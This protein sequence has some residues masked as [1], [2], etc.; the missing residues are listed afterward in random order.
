MTPPSPASSWHRLL[1]EA[2]A[3]S[4]EAFGRL[5][6]DIRP[7]LLVVARDELDAELR[8]KLGASDLVQDSLLLAHDRLGQFQGSSPEQFKGWL[9]Q[10]L[11]RRAANWRRHYLGTAMRHAG[12]EVP[13]LDQPGPAGHGV[14]EPACPADTPGAA[15]VRREEREV[16]RRALGRLPEDYRRVLLLRTTE[17]RP[18]EEVGRLLGRSADA[19]R[20]LWGRA[21]EALQAELGDQP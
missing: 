10:I 14:A 15:F 9:R 1:A 21:V 8:A 3:G 12:R 17:R 7:Y 2:R 18:F 20:M 13:L 6:D 11:L 19:A 4:R 16:V 5:L